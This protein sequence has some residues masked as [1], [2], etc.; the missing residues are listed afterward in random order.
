MKKYEK[1]EVFSKEFCNNSREQERAQR[2][3][4]ESSREQL[5]KERGKMKDEVEGR[6]KRVQGLH[7]TSISCLMSDMTEEYS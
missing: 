2:T 7:F 1:E 6:C 5:G 4:A 3:A